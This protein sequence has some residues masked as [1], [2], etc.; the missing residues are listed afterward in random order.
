MHA[1]PLT[2]QSVPPA[3]PV[4]QVPPT[5]SQH[6]VLHWSVTP[7]TTQVLLHWWVVVLHAWLVGQSAT[8]AQPHMPLMH[9]LVPLHGP[10]VAPLVPHAE[11]DVLVMQVPVALQHPVGHVVGVQFATQ[12]PFEHVC[13]E[14]QALHEAPFRPQPF[15][16]DV[17]HWP[18]VEQHPPAQ[19]VGEQFERHDPAE[20]VWVESQVVHDAPPVPQVAFDD[21]SHCPVLEQQPEQLAALQGTLVS[22]PPESSPP[23][24]WPP[25]LL[26]AAS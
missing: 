7:D 4:W 26:V 20:H 19:R 1:P 14:L 2:P 5:V 21:V 3:A 17:M 16:P 11:L 8:V 23:E 18:V 25:L 12:V 22:S 10:H 6:P 24:S 13:V 9:W 15:C